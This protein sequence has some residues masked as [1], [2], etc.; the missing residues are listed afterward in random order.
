MHKYAV[1]LNKDG[2]ILAYLYDTSAF[3]DAIV[4]I[5]SESSLEGTERRERLRKRKVDLLGNLEVEAEA[6]GM[7]KARLGHQRTPRL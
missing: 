2:M 6:T 5:P 3:S 7:N 1:T 4:G